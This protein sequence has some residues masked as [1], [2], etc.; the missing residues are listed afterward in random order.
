MANTNT[1]TAAST[2]KI[3]LNDIDA[4][5]MLDFSGTMATQDAG[6]G[7]ALTRLA[8]MRESAKAFAAELEKHDSDGITIVKFAG[9]VKIY[10]GVT[11]TKVDEIFME[12]RAMG[13]TA[14]DEAL[15]QISE[16][17][18]AKR[19]SDKTG[20]PIFVGIFTDGRPD[21]QVGL[22]E[23]IVGITKQIKSR[24]E[25]GILFVQVGKDAD[26]AGYL[27]K[28]NNDLEGAGASHDIVAVCK[29]DDLEDLTTE[30]IVEMAF[31]E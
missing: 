26:A 23:Q 28:L 6:S 8:A 18:L 24:K 15:K 27:A 3:N 21:N 4:V 30:E 12:N 31:T 10:D 13:G 7:G 14:T 2:T 19:A 17:F 9:K 11:S 16:K 1:T 22:A 20:R 29:L 25:F 5:L